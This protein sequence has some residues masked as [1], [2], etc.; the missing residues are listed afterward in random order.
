MAII[1]LGRDG[2]ADVEVLELEPGA[3]FAGRRVGESL[4]LKETPALVSIEPT[5][6]MSSLRAVVPIG[7]TCATVP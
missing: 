6:T 2:L 1:S 7:D 5:A 3:L 4:S